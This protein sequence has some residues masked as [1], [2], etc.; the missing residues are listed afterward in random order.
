MVQNMLFERAERRIQREFGWERYEHADGS[1]LFPKDAEQ[2][3]G[4]RGLGHMMLRGANGNGNRHY[5]LMTKLDIVGEQE[6]EDLPEAEKVGDR[7][8]R[9]NFRDYCMA[10]LRMSDSRVMFVKFDIKQHKGNMPAI[11]H[12]DTGELEIGVID[13]ETRF[14]WRRPV[15]GRLVSYH[16]T[17]PYAPWLAIDDYDFS[18][19][20]EDG[21]H[22][23][24][25]PIPLRH[26]F[27]RFI[28]RFI[29]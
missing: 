10:A 3:L 7:Q 16:N 21:Y 5:T 24:L 4:K 25:D 28:K 2:L 8:L 23:S 19:K 6:F 17:D 26:V 27:P 1:A 9:Y 29:G 12:P 20:E 11:R 14:K 15:D 22:S 13:A 18:A